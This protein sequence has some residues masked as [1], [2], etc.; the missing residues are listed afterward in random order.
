MSGCSAPARPIL[1]DAQL[2]QRAHTDSE[3]MAEALHDAVGRLIVRVQEKE[4]ESGPPVLNILALSGGGDYGA[5]GAGFL[6]GWGTVQ[7]PEWRRPDFD[8]VTGVSTGAMLAPFAYIGTDETCSQ[9]NAFYRDPKPD[10]IEERGLLYFLPSN[11]SFMTLPGLE[12]DLRHAVDEPFVDQMAAQSAKGK[13]LIV[14][15][16][17]L[18][19]GRQK[20]WDVGMLAEEASTSGDPRPVQEVM[21]ASASIPVVFPPTGISESIYA[22]GGITA[23]V[24]LR[25]DWRNPNAFIPRWRAANPGKPLPKVRYWIIINNQLTHAPKTVQLKWPAIAAPSLEIA[26]RSATLAEVAL[27]AAEA[28][29]V[30]AAFNADIEVRVVGI[31]SDWRPPVEGDFEKPT[32]DS[33]S[34]LGRKL[35]ADPASWKIWA[36]PNLTDMPVR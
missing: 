29:Y 32:M 20:F 1:T 34:D 11:P 36:A 35:G 16:T 13:V 17:D 19:L 18:D 25:L 10:W 14:S 33:L 2:A 27:L 7:D 15:A 21:L 3:E 26:I 24:F 31:P 28:D 5:F 12:R 22:D 4:A 30:N 9:V 23:N 6:V 8:V